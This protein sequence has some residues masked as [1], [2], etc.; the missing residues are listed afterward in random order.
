[1]PFKCS[2]SVCIILIPTNLPVLEA[3][4]KARFLNGK[5]LLYY[6]VFSCFHIIRSFA[7]KVIFKGKDKK[8]QRE[9]YLINREAASLVQICV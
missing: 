2:P 9:P 8:Y 5:Q 1:M 7:F 3:L 4:L 6:I